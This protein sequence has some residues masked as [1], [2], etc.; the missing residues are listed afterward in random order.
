MS[1]MHR[2]FFFLRA[3]AACKL[4]HM[5]WNAGAGRSMA[6]Q[7][8]QPQRRTAAGAAWHHD[9][10]AAAQ[11]GSEASTA[12]TVRVSTTSPGRATRSCSGLPMCCPSSRINA[13]VVTASRCGRSPKPGSEA[14]NGAADSAVGGA[15][16]CGCGRRTGSRL[17]ESV[18][19]G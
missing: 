18:R 16:G 7:Q 15:A 5:T 11:C 1:E 13:W 9:S 4:L 8:P 10:R 6:Q 19:C 2:Y 12:T 3:A 17:V 14:G